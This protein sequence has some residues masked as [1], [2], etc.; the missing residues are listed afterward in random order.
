MET[1]SAFMAAA[2]AAVL[3][4]AV[5]LRRRD[6]SG[7]LL[8]GLAATF[9]A[10]ALGRGLLAIGIEWG[11]IVA[12]VAL[13]AIGPLA[14]A[15]VWS[16][17]ARIPAAGRILPAAAVAGLGV[18]LLPLLPGGDRP[19]MASLP[20]LF[21]GTLIVFSALLLRR[22]AST[23]T[24]DVPGQRR[25]GYVATSH[26]LVVAA[27]AGDSLLGAMDAP[28]GVT[29]FA[30]LLYLYVAY[31]HLSH[32][33]VVDLRQLF[34]NTLALAAI[35]AGLV[36]F[37][38]ALHLW[39]GEQTDLFVLNAFVASF[40]LLL[41]Y[42]PLG[43]GVQYAMDRW[44]VGAKIALARSL[45]PLRSRLTQVLTL[46]E[47]LREF[48]RT[49]ERTERVTSSSIFLRDDPRMGF[50][51]AAG[52]GLPRGP[53]VNLIRDPVFVE[54]LQTGDPLLAEDLERAEA[55]DPGGIVGRP[56]AVVLRTLQELD[57]QL[58]IPL[59]SGRNLVGFWTLTHADSAEPFSSEEV[60]LLCDLADQ[61]AVS[62]ENSKTF[63]RIRARD[64]LVSL[65]EMAAGLAHEIRNPIATIRGALALFDD[66][67]KEDPEE[68]RRLVVEE[69]H[70]LDRVVGLFLDYARPSPPHPT[71]QNVFQILEHA[72]SGTRAGA[73]GVHVELDVEPG[74][75]ALPIDGERLERIVSNLVRN[76]CEACEE[77][78]T[79]RITAQTSGTV[80][81][82]GLEI[83][84]V[85]E[86]VG[87]DDDT[88]SRAFVPF[89]T[90]KEEGVGLGLAL[91]ERLVRAQGG[92]IE[93]R[94]EA[95]RGTR[96]R[97]WIPL[98]RETEAPPPE[99]AER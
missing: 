85:D 5:L 60:R 48:L 71:P 72:V 46:D 92:E 10:W 29:Y 61:A 30:A 28:R 19:G 79:V 37:F 13:G 2:A 88:L 86:G 99:A 89:F 32:V 97:L 9:G 53:T 25:L 6:R 77:G 17:G 45:A 76:A 11:E 64:R 40:L 82:S 56:P 1:Q 18:A 54:A 80:E 98:A 73:N 34:G 52:V 63:E 22:G 51:L 44:L 65:G 55:E 35:A 57:T 95:G 94:S 42:D 26:A 41:F 38:S 4:A 12:R 39:V 87:M 62:I 90:T 50:Q 8:S 15:F 31:L 3:V 47:L 20:T 78:S 14:L 27:I 91:C 23:G 21:A 43:R 69:V 58:V 36:G 68:I 96:A 84:V 59:R 33:R 70:R 75:E 93:L 74:L 7:L 49:L 83:L 16:L 67:G 66:P 81:S 24:E